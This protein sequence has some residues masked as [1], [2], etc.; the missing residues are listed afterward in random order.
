MQEKDKE[1]HL[2]ICMAGAITAGS[3][4]SGVMDYLLETMEHWQQEKDANKDALN[5]KETIPFPDTP[6]YDVVIDVLSGASAGGMCAVIATAMVAQGVNIQNIKTKQSKMYKSW[7]DIDDDNIPEGTLKKMLRTD[8]IKNE[9]II[10]LLNSKP[11]TALSQ[12]MITILPKTNLPSYVN[13]KLDTLV[14]LANLRGTKYFIEFKS[15]GLLKKHIIT[16]H[17]DFMHFRLN[18]LTDHKSD[19]LEMNF[20]DPENVRLLQESA[21]ATGAFPVG[22]RAR[23]LQRNA[24]YYYNQADEIAGISNLPENIV[25]FHS[26]RSSDCYYESL[27]VDGGTF[28]NEPFGE[29]ERVLNSK[30]GKKSGESLGYQET[31][32]TILMIDPFPSNAEEADEDDMCPEL[33]KVIPRIIGALREQSSFKTEDLVDALGDNN[34]LKFIITPAKDCSKQPL[35]CAT[36]GAFGGFL[37]KEFRE[38]DYQ[39]GRR[40]A[41][42]FLRKHFGMPYSELEGENNNPIHNGWTKNAIT[43]YKEIEDEI[44]YLPIIP[45]VQKKSDPLDKDDPSE[46]KLPELPKYPLY[47]LRELEKPL[48]KRVKAFIKASEEKMG[49]QNSKKSELK[50]VKEWYKKNI[51]VVVFNFIISFLCFPIVFLVLWIAKYKLR[52]AVV[53][54]IITWILSDLNKAGL[55]ES[56]KGK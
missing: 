29:T 35:C 10:S 34:Y 56:G 37:Y 25:I 2:G 39:L 36:L 46:V 28:N 31:N 48:N 17:R 16:L 52:K 13:P 5:K 4:T 8:D 19:F 18:E 43:K 50:V 53:K 33:I 51:I 21:V 55:L 42:Q 3:Y 9:G 44:T 32:R 49:N 40:N 54:E 6:M 22:L 47:K 12:K 20:S 1:F 26:N 14:T 7:I 38:H 27:N 11:I 23:G 45:D 24:Q 41:Q 15:Y 30:S